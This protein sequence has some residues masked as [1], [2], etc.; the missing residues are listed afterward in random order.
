MT[1]NTTSRL[2][3][4]VL[5][6]LC[7]AMTAAWMPAG[8]ANGARSSTATGDI[9]A[10]HDTYNDVWLG[11]SSA[12][13]VAQKNSIDLRHFTVRRAGHKVR[14]IAELRQ[15]ITGRRWDQML[16][17]TF[18]A[19]PAGSADWSSDFGATTKGRGYAYWT[20]N[21]NYDPIVNCHVAVAVHRASAT[22]VVDVPPRCI[23]S[24]KVKMKVFTATGYFET[25]APAYSRD[26]FTVAGRYT[27]KD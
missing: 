2:L 25:D 6:V 22:V 4:G 10:T 14:F 19:S 27:V 21:Q 13:S 12:L 26:R 1:P 11:R 5:A 7:L 15:I 9:V 23:P 24:G 8:A 18:A 3:G 16:F 17:V 20:P